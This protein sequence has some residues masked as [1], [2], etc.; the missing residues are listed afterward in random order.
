MGQIVG[1]HTWRDVGLA[2]LDYLVIGSRANDAVDSGR[3]EEEVDDDVHHLL[4]DVQ[5]R[6]VEKEKR[7]ERKGTCQDT[8]VL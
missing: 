8:I 4:E 1:K 6:H 3:E 7:R 2:F 5:S